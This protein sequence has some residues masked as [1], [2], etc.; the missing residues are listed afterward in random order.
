MKLWM[1]KIRTFDNDD[2]KK[3]EDR[4]IQ[5][6]AGDS[7]RAV[8]QAYKQLSDPDHYHKVLACTPISDVNK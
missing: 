5:V 3:F 2:R 6:V 1:V 7:K 4:N 8:I